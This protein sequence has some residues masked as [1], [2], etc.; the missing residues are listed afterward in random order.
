MRHSRSG[1]T[2]IEVMVAILILALI[3]TLTGMTI[4][5]SL[6]AR[7]ALSYNDDM[8]QSARVALNKISRELQ[9]AYLSY[10][11]S[12]PNTYRTVFVAKDTDPVDSIWFATLAHQRLYRNSAECDQAEVTIWAEDDPY[13][14]GHYVLMH[15]ES[16]RIDHEPGKDGTIYPLAYGVRQFIVRYLN[17][18]T[19]LWQEEW[20]SVNGEEIDTL[21]R[22]AQIVLILS[23]ID[24]DEEDELREH[25]FATTVVL[26]Y[27]R[28]VQ[29]DVFEGEDQ[30]TNSGEADG[31][32]GLP[33]PSG[34]GVGGGR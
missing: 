1:M 34:G 12:T 31:R 10:N 14:D 6:K 18:T 25:T 15:R 8:Q 2:L 28:K 16:P 29:C 3:A 9:L 23:S 4:A 32:T 30:E 5:G 22:A 7:D 17:P 33:S 27:G 21:P 26:E 11:R 19:C 13:L 24:P 20:D